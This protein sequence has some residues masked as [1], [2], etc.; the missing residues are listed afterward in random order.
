MA[1]LIAFLLALGGALLLWQASRQ[2]RASGLPPGRIVYMDSTAWE[3][4][5]KPLYDP[6]TNLT[7]KPDYLIRQGEMLIPVEVK[8]TRVKDAPYDGHLYQ[9]AAYCLL[10]ERSSGVRPTHGILHYA[11]RT[12]EIPYTPA[13]EYALLNT[14]NEMR[15]EARRRRHPRSHENP[16]RCKRCGYR[17]ICDQKLA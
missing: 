10:V 12:F 16:A 14:L 17:H 7:G 9:L 5:P 13:L 8:S 1:L 15:A 2:Q 11:N 6:A 4:A 3:E